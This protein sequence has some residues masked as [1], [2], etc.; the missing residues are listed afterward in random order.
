MNSEDWT[1]IAICADARV[2]SRTFSFDDEDNNILG[3]LET[4]EMARAQAYREVLIGAT[5][6]D[7][8]MEIAEAFN[9]KDLIEEVIDKK[10]TGIQIDIITA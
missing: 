4:R 1:N 6:M 5:Y 10:V 8:T 9:R 3:D 2:M 7:I